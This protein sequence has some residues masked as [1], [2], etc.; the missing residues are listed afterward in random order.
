MFGEFF[1]EV[2]G[3]F[4]GVGGGVEL[5]DD[6]AA[7][8]F[9]GFARMGLGRVEE[10]SD[11]IFGKRG[12]HAE[13]VGHEFVGD[14]HGFAELFGGGIG[15]ADVIAEGFGHFLDA[16]GADEDGHDND[17]LRGLVFGFLEVAAD[18]VVEGLISAAEFD[19]G[20][21][22]DGVPALH[23][24]VHE[25]VDVDGFAG[26]VAF[27]EG[28]AFEH[29]CDGHFLAELEGIDE[30]HFVEPFGVVAEFDFF[31]GHV[32]DFSGLFEVGFGVGIDLF[33][34]EDGAGFLFAGGVADHGGGVADDEDG[35]VAQIL[36]LAHFSEDDGVTEVKVGSGGIHAEFDA[37]LTAGAGGVFEAFLQFLGGIDVVGAGEEELHLL[38]DGEGGGH[39]GTLFPGESKTIP[40]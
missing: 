16:V 29:S 10:G 6:G 28:V 19:V 12:G 7:E 3:G 21:D 24:G 39:R 17:D 18:E 25:F 22:H 23:E 33:A 38:I 15:D 13:P 4:F 5:F 27:L 40:L 26:F 1:A 32:E 34:G 36:E 8:D 37:E 20:F 9:L 31:G 2:V 11:D 35:L 14:G 30:G